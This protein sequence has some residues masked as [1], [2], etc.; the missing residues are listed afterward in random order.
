MLHLYLFRHAKSSR[1]SKGIEDFDRPLNARGRTAATRM[2]DH[3]ARAGIAP[4]LILCS[5]ARRARETLARTIPAFGQ[6]CAIR[7]ERRLYLADSAMLLDRVQS[8][9]AGSARC[10]L[11][12]HNPGLH[13]LA[14]LLASDGAAD[15]MDSLR[16]G[17]PTGAIAE[18]A[19]ALRRWDEIAPGA[20][21]LQ[22][23]MTPRNL[24]SHR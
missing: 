4:D 14:R 16:T 10:M 18:I 8:L 15:A 21:L 13:Q 3:M 12:G 24:P 7:I 19:F 9:P 17:F 1:I 22:C 5:A 23:F 6:D 20:G 11:I 2:A